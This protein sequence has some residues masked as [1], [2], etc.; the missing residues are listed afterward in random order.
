[1]SNVLTFTG[2]LGADAEVRYTASGLAVLSFSVAMDSGYGSN[3]KTDWVRVSMFGKVAES[4]LKNYLLKGTA[5]FVSG[6]SSLNIYQANDGTTK[7]LI[8]L[9]ANIAKPVG[10][11]RTDT[12]NPAQQAPR[13]AATNQPPAATPHDNFDAPF[14]DDIP[15]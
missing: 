6:E 15:F 11:K 3:K 2:N 1:M 7:A 10:G 5:V 12:P 13:P 8:N 14:D 4:T 9:V